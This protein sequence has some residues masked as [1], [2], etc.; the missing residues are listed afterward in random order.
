[1]ELLLSIVQN[2]HRKKQTHGPD[3]NS[4]VKYDSVWT[5][6]TQTCPIITPSTQISKQF[7]SEVSLSL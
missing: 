2:L 4:L 3:E 7:I 5:H 1:M 6:L